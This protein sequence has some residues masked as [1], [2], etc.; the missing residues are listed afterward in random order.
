YRLTEDGSQPRFQAANWPAEVH[1]LF[2]WSGRSASTANFLD[3]LAQ[4]KSGHGGEYAAHM[5]GLTEIAERASAA[6]AAGQA[7]G[8]IEGAAAYASAL[9]DFGAAC[10]LEIFSPEH[11]RLTALATE[12]GVA[13]KPCGAGGGDFGVVFALEPAKL[14]EVQ[15]RI[16]GAGFRC[17][18]LA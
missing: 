17:V 15:K 18:P 3:R 5:R 9:K 7:R 10:G 12:S 6:A 1:A 14:A 2:I 4:W 13:Y 8:F 11:E 16:T